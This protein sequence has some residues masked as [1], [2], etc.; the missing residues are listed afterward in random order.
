MSSIRYFKGCYLYVYSFFLSLKVIL[1]Q[2]LKHLSYSCLF[3]LYGIVFEWVLFIYFESWF[4]C[5]GCRYLDM[6]DKNRFSDFDIPTYFWFLSCRVV[7]MVQD[8]V[9]QL[10]FRTVRKEDFGNYT[11]RA[12][13]KLGMAD[14]SFKLTGWYWVLLVRVWGPFPI[15][16]DLPPCS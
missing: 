14:V 16:L 12:E 8:N 3:L 6:F 9:H 4:H 13:N 10:I 2:S 15:I 5:G 11:F 1:Q 7:I